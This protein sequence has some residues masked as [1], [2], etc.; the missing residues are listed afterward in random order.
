[1]KRSVLPTFKRCYM[2]VYSGVVTQALVLGKE[3]GAVLETFNKQQQQ[4][5]RALYFGL[6]KYH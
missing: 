4:V 3:K 2:F 1:M 6:L 5:D